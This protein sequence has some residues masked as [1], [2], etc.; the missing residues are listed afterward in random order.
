MDNFKKFADTI[1]SNGG[2][3]LLLFVLFGCCLGMF[4]YNHDTAVKDFCMMILGAL[5]GILRGEVQKKISPMNGFD[6]T[7]VEQTKTEITP[8]TTE[9]KKD[10]E[11]K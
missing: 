7:V 3:I 8:S 1:A 11:V 5:L 9:T 6:Q 4:A 10:D 2:T